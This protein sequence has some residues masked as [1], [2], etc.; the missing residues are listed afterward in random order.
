MSEQLDF[1]S[2]HKGAQFECKSE[3]CKRRVLQPNTICWHCFS[4]VVTGKP[5]KGRKR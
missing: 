4:K 2:L 5:K 3:D 1:D